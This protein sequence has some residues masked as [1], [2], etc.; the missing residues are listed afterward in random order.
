M[1]IENFIVRL[2][3]EEDNKRADRKMGNTVVAKANVV[4]HGQ[5]SIGKKKF[6]SSKGSKLGPKGGISNKPKF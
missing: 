4:E 5:S 6:P 3:I 1:K 2:R